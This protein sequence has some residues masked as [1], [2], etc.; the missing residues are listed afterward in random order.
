[1]KI[2]EE[3]RTSWTYPC[4]IGAIDG[5]HIAI[6]NPTNCGSG[7]F[8]YKHFISV[9]LLA[10][11]DANYKFIYVETGATGRSGDA[12][13]FSESA[14]KKAL[15]GNTLNLPPP[16][17]VEGILHCK[18]NHHFVG[19]Y[20]FSLTTTM[21]KPYPQR[22]LDKPKRIFNYRLSRARRV[23][24]NSFGILAS[25]F[26]V[27]LTTIRLPPEKVT[28]LILAGCCLHNYLVETNKHTY[29]SA[30]DVEHVNHTITPGSWRSDQALTGMRPGTNRTR[31]PT[32]NAKKQ[33]K[34][35]MNYFS[36][37]GAVPWQDD[38]INPQTK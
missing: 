37:A 12:G 13:V 27:F 6:Q 1:M 26:R 17:D 18:I 3:F 2:S 38:I 21:M 5:K 33:R 31:N 20:V 19:D 14:L 10:I 25:R 16:A 35:L 36:N 11:V 32:K 30:C 8:N 34:L 9:L 15:D 22:L 28:Y 24:E 7:F 4:C 29:T 23:V